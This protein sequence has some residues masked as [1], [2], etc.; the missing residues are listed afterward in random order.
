MKAFK[1]I[2]LSKAKLGRKSIKFENDQLLLYT[3][4]VKNILK[5]EYYQSIFI[6]HKKTLFLNFRLTFSITSS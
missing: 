2:K 6:T 3:N 1:I 5:N 4:L